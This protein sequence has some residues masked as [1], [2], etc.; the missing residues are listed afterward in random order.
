GRTRSRTT[1]DQVAAK[2]AEALRDP[3]RCRHPASR[4]APAEALAPTAGLDARSPSARY[5]SSDYRGVESRTRAR[6][7]RCNVASRDGEGSARAVGADLG[8]GPQGGVPV[9]VSQRVAIRSRHDTW[10]AVV[11]T[12]RASGSDFAVSQPRDRVCP[13]QSARLPPLLR[14]QLHP[15]RWRHLPT[16]AHPGPHVHRDDAV[17][18]AVDGTRTLAGRPREVFAAR[19]ARITAIAGRD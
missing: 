14:G 8:R 2:P 1:A 18:S 19:A 7:S 3:K 12:K 13:R 9:V 15:Q 16:V 4:H 5:G 10:S 11:P 17:V 6:R